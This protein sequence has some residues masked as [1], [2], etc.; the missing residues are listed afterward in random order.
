MLDQT[1]IPCPCLWFSLPPLLTQHHVCTLLCAQ[2]A[3]LG[4]LRML[5][6]SHGG[7]LLPRSDI[8]LRLAFQ[9]ADGMAYL[10]GREPPVIHHDLKSLNILCFSKLG[11]SKLQELTVD[12]LEGL[13]LKICDFGLA[14]GLGASAATMLQSTSRGG[15]AMGG[16][17]AYCAPEFFE[18]IYTASSEV[19][20]YGVIVSEL[21]TAKVPWSAPDPT[22]R[23]PYTLVTL[24]LAVSRGVRPE[25]PSDSDSQMLAQLAK[26]CWQGEASLR[27]TFEQIANVLRESPR[28]RDES[29]IVVARKTPAGTSASHAKMHHTLAGRNDRLLCS[30]K[31]YTEVAGMKSF[32]PSALRKMRLTA[33]DGDGGSTSQDGGGGSLHQNEGGGSSSSDSARSDAQIAEGLG[34]VEA[35]SAAQK[36][37]LYTLK[38]SVHRSHRADGYNEALKSFGPTARVRHAAASVQDASCSLPQDPATP[39]AAQALGAVSQSLLLDSVRSALGTSALE[40]EEAEELMLPPPTVLPPP[41]ASHAEGDANSPTPGAFAAQRRP[42]AQALDV[43]APRACLPPRLT[44]SD[45]RRAKKSPAAK[46]T[47]A[48]V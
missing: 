31:D 23:R 27:P 2:L 44:G 43:E 28:L 37:L 15:G 20:S 12:M 3:D 45:S 10:H 41:K 5:L 36:K 19:Y 16:T 17:L 33:Q 32:G 7:L 9:I 1:Y 29:T 11:R 25:L 18:G 42:A 34:S 48:Y 40:V 24:K 30:H 22:T 21:L 35:S 13:R 4:S 26:D 39:A 46:E 6:D 14:T 8:Q 38:H 47:L